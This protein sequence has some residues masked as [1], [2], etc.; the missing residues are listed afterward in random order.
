VLASARASFQSLTPREQQVIALVTSG[1]MNKQ[2]AAKLG[3]TEITVKVHRGNMMRKMG[4]RSLA[5][6]VRMADALGVQRPGQ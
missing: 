1:L 4:V 5:E 2:I 3:V 6:L